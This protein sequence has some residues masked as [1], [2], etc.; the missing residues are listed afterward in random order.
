MTMRVV[1]LL[2]LSTVLMTH[3][4]SERRRR[5]PKK[6]PHRRPPPNRPK[7]KSHGPPGFSVPPIG[8]I[9]IEWPD[10]SD[11]CPDDGGIPK[12]E[13]TLPFTK[14]SAI[15]IFQW[16]AAMQMCFFDFVNDE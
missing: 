13:G 12:Y 10:D 7:R 8:D 2:L 5:K 1:L 16:V 3:G 6:P 14:D 9:L 11:L 15:D 4:K